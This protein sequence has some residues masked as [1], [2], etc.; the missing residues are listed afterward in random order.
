M[1]SFKLPVIKTKAYFALKECKYPKVG[2]ARH[3]KV[4]GQDERNVVSNWKCIC[5]SAILLI[6]RLKQ[7]RRCCWRIAGNQW[8]EMICPGV[9]IGKR[10]LTLEREHPLPLL[11]VVQVVALEFTEVIDPRSG[12]GFSKDMSSRETVSSRSL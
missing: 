5:V 7:M 3:Y 8:V 10:G 2:S 9:G 11:S 4:G 1:E 6:S 12:W